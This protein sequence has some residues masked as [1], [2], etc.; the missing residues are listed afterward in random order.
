MTNL[1]VTAVSNADATL[2]KLQITRFTRITVKNFT[3]R[4][5]IVYNRES[6]TK[7]IM[8]AN[9]FK[10]ITNEKLQKKKKEEYV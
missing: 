9:I 10:R 8:R 2:S 1:L 3:I 6:L 7:L 4:F 5:W